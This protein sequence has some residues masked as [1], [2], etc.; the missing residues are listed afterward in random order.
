MNYSCSPSIKRMIRFRFACYFRIL[1]LV[2]VFSQSGAPAMA[3]SLHEAAAKGDI[4]A[5][6]KLVAEGEYINFRDEGGLTALHWAAIKGHSNVVEFL[7]D[8]GANIKSKDNFGTTLLHMAVFG[9]EEI[10]KLLLDEGISV[11]EKNDDGISALHLAALEGGQTV[12]KLL[13]TWGG[14][15]NAASIKNQITPLYWAAKRGHLAL[16]ELLIANGAEV[17]ARTKRGKTPLKAAIIRVTGSWLNYFSSMGA[18]SRVEKWGKP[19]GRPE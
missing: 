10:V 18:G 14:D 1:I 15:V 9:G 4:D 11:N 8:S 16:V 19:M 2:T 5:V 13:V 3:A 6:R 12:A 7:I 17:N